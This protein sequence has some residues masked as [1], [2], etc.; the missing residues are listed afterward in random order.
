MVSRTVTR[1]NI[2]RKGFGISDLPQDH[3]R[4]IEPM[5]AKPAQKVPESKD[6]LYEV[7]LDGYRCLAGRGRKGVTLWSRRGNLF[8]NQFP[9][10]AR[11][12]EVLEPDTLIDGEVVALDESGRSSFTVLQHHRSKARAILFYAFDLPIY[13]GRSLLIVPLEQRRELLT[14]ALGGIDGSD[15][16]LIRISETF[17]GSPAA[18]ISAVEELEFEGIVAKKKDSLYESGQRSGSTVLRNSSSEGRGNAHS[19]SPKSS[20]TDMPLTAMKHVDADQVVP[21]APRR[22]WAATQSRLRSKERWQSR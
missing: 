1:G 19:G 7:K 8:T 20:L 21:L 18:L 10:I 22:I 11:A 16:S 12:C 17:S 9:A 15:D 13:R 6:W 2:Q 14:Q 5:Y 4:F 3:P